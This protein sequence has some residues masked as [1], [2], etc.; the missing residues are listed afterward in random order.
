MAMLKWT[1]LTWVEPSSHGSL[2]SRLQYVANSL[3]DELGGAATD[4]GEPVWLALYESPDGRPL[5]VEAC[6]SRSGVTGWSA[7]PECSAV[8][9]VG[10][11]TVT[12]A[13]QSGNATRPSAR[14]VLCCLL[15]RDGHLAWSTSPGSVLPQKPPGEGR[16]FDALHR[17]LGLSTPAAP[18]GIA[19]LLD[20]LWVTAVIDA[21][22]M[23]HPVCLTWRQ[24]AGLHPLRDPGAT[25]TGLLT[26]TWEEVR[27]AAAAGTWP[28]CP[29][30]PDAAA[31]MDEG[32]FARSVLEAL[33]S[34]QESYD[35]VSSRLTPS[36]RRRLACW[37]G[38]RPGG[39]RNSAPSGPGSP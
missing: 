10:S 17:C 5:R 12:R 35:S 26:A 1:V 13:T 34:A 22:E 24:V 37:L 33:P 29:V 4:L 31:W 6:H 8:G 28:R 3:L 20:A 25:G 38:V 30:T 2:P 27:L 23:A 7:P 15:S 32:M 16:L 14:I 39:S 18:A 9:L 21:A 11:A 19:L 36:A